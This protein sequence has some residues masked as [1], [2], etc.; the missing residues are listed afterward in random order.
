MSGG[1]GDDLIIG[2]DG[3]DSLDGGYVDADGKLAGGGR[4]VLIGLGGDDTLDGF[5]ADRLHGGT[6]I[7]VLKFAEP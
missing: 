4:D 1:L 2:S 6:G 7:D 5:C 3:D